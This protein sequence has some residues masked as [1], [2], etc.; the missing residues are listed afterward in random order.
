MRGIDPFIVL[1]A[2]AVFD[3]SVLRELGNAFQWPPH[4]V[5]VPGEPLSPI[6]FASLKGQFPSSAS[7]MILRAAMVS[8]PKQA[9]PNYIATA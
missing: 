9:Q 4:A 6:E 2:C 7:F 1:D 8:P 5:R 3:G